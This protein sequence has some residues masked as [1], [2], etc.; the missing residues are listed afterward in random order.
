MDTSM[1]QKFILAQSLKN[2]SN[3]KILINPL[4]NSHKKASEICKKDSLEI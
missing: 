3:I 1:L 4:K 2:P